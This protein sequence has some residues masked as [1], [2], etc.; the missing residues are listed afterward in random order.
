[1]STRRSSSTSSSRPGTPSAGRVLALP[2]SRAELSSQD[3]SQSPE[4]SS[5]SASA[6][7][8]RSCAEAVS[9]P[10]SAVWSRLRAPGPGLLPLPRW[11]EGPPAVLPRRSPRGVEGAE[12]QRGLAD[13]RVLRW[14]GEPGVEGAERPQLE[15]RGVERWLDGGEEPPAPLAPPKMPLTRLAYEPRGEVGAD[16]T[17]LW[18]RPAGGGAPGARG[19]RSSLSCACRR[20]PGSR[21]LR[22]RRRTACL[23]W[24]LHLLTPG[25]LRAFTSSGLRAA[26]GA[27][28][29][30][31]A[32]GRR[33][34]SS[35]SARVWWC[36]ASRR[37]LHSS[38]RALR[39]AS[40]SS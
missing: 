39:Q 20:S 11:R 30:C 31:G 37:R 17:R 1:M 26:P 14:A 16:C 27:S 22:R 29:G 38:S 23:S 3:S 33:R 18:K 40:C 15:A 7:S 6:A 36:W 10:K 25:G 28:P 9:Q 34:A 5:S 2:G 13:A 24:T 8:A 4:Y 19:A 12:L 32:R 21:S 35:S